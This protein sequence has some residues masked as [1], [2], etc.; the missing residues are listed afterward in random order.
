MPVGKQWFR[1]HVN[2]RKR[3]FDLVGVDGGP[4]VKQLHP[5]RSTQMFFSSGVVRNNTDEWA[6]ANPNESQGMTWTG[7][8][9]FTQRDALAPFPESGQPGEGSGSG[10]T[11]A[12]TFDPKLI[13]MDKPWD[14]DT[15]LVPTPGAD[16]GVK[17]ERRPD[18]VL[19]Q[20][21]GQRHVPCGP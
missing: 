16:I 2:P 10:G 5:A 11:V 4:N 14:G 8:T 9:I 17:F 1:I 21:A 18:G 20:K 6:D 19:V 7:M 12:G 15:P 3:L 13:D